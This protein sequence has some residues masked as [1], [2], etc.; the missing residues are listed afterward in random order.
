MCGVVVGVG[1]R[2]CEVRRVCSEGE[3]QVVWC[4]CE[5]REG[6]SVP[7]GEAGGRGVGCEVGQCE[8]KGEECRG[9]GRERECDATGMVQ[10]AREVRGP[11]EG[12]AGQSVARESVRGYRRGKRCS[13]Q[14]EGGTV[15]RQ[16]EK[17]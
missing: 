9:R 3:G 1:E 16:R 2:W 7:T 13:V 15:K 17:R 11:S 14:V 5:S 6:P 12:S 10:G 8:G 4:R